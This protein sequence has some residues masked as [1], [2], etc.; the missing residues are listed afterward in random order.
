[1]CVFIL[2]IL[3]IVNCVNGLIMTVLSNRY[4]YY[5]YITPLYTYNSP[6]VMYRIN[7]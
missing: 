5:I 3:F 7:G 2:F 4:Y 6:R 1:M